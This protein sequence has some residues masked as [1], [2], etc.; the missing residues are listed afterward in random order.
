[1]GPPLEVPLDLFRRMRD[2]A[3]HRRFC[4]I[5]GP[6]RRC[7][8]PMHYRAFQF[9]RQVPLLHTGDRRPLCCT[10]FRSNVSS[11][12]KIQIKNSSCP[13]PLSAGRIALTR[14]SPPADFQPGRR[15]RTAPAQSVRI[16][17]EPACPAS[18]KQAWERHT[19]PC[20]PHCRSGRR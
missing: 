6:G 15:S 2:C 16:R 13:W 4:F 20:L 1:M 7:S 14:P 3:M 5:L 19:T 10:A 9:V 18:W 8:R 11:A 17:A 12:F